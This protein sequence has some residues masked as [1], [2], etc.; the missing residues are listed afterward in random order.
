[1]ELPLTSGAAMMVSE[2]YVEWVVK[3]ANNKFE[4]NARIIEKLMKHHT[5]ELN[6]F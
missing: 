4:Q 5:G 1:M 3:L 6:A 2:A